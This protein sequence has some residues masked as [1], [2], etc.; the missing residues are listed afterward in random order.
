[1]IVSYIPAMSNISHN[2][3]EEQ[4]HRGR[5][6]EFDI[7]RALDGA[8]RVFS[9]RGYHATSVGDLTDAMELAQGS[10][11]KAFKDKKAIFIA[12]MERYRIVQTERFEAAV[13]GYDTGRERLR[14]G[15]M[16]YAE[17]SHGGAGSDGCLVVGAAADLAALDDD[18]AVV[19]ERAVKAR[20][21]IVA[22][23]VAEGQKDGSVNSKVDPDDLSRAMLCMMYGMRVVGKTGRSL[24]DMVAVVD[25]AMK[26]AE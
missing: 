19:V 25:I 4:R 12:T 10:L 9:R 5:P 13:A 16:F 18:I 20:E 21:R 11:Y 26:L 15:L 6:R 8:I 3:S 17:R 22:R 23:L 14:A 1:M 24:K 7:D 2:Q